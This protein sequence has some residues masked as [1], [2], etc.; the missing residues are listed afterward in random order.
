[1]LFRPVLSN[2]G[3]G[4]DL[5]LGLELFLACLP[6]KNIIGLKLIMEQE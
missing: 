1:V 4:I 5:F 6:D 2:T 3:N